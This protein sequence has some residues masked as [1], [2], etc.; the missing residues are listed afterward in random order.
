MGGHFRGTV[1]RHN[2]DL[3]DGLGE[4][5][6]QQV[7]QFAADVVPDRGGPRGQSK[8][9]GEPRVVDFDVLDLVELGDA[10]P[11]FGVL[12]PGQRPPGPCFLLLPWLSS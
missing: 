9:H 1:A 2:F 12:E 10:S 4:L 8:G 11:G 7:F 3:D 6:P 5:S